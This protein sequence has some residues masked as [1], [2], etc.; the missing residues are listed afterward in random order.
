MKWNEMFLFQ[1]LYLNIGPRI[2]ND[3]M[4]LILFWKDFL[5]DPLA[6]FNKPVCGRPNTAKVIFWKWGANMNKR[7]L[8]NPWQGNITKCQVPFA[9]DIWRLK[10]SNMW[11][12]NNC[13]EEYRYS[14]HPWPGSW[15]WRITCHLEIFTREK[16]VLWWRQF[17]YIF[18]N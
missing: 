3:Q 6:I 7:G 1:K 11:T 8:P 13:P 14:L 15:C 10:T 9:D 12:A 18:K 16:L 17:D 2:I 5:N 4:P